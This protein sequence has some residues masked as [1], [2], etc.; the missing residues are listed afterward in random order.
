M[1]VM[2][3]KLSNSQCPE[4]P[5]KRILGEYVSGRLEEPQLGQCEA[6]LAHCDQCEETVRGMFGSDTAN[7]SF[8]GLAVEAL[9][10]EDASFS[11]D[12][13]LVD[14]LIR[15]LSGKTPD[16]DRDARALEN[17]AAEVTRLLPASESDGAVG[18]V[19]G[20]Q[21]I[22]LLGAGSTGI[23]YEATDQDLNRKVALKI[24]R[25]S[26]GDAA[27]DRFM[28]EAR[29]AAAIS[30]PNVITIYQVGV[31][32]P[33]A[34]IAME[35][36]EGQTLESRL[37]EVAFVPQDDIKKIGTQVAQGLAAAHRNG[38][39][40]RDIK[41]ANVWLKSENDQAVILDFGLARIADDD[42][43]MTATGMLAGT[44][45][46]M[47][48]EQ[49]RGLEL[50][51][52]SDL[53]SLGCLMYRASTGKLPF[54]TTGIL[55]TLQSIQHDDPRAPK[56]LNPHV[57]EDFSDLV[58]ALLEKQPVNRP[59]TADQLVEA[60]QS[61]RKQ[62]PF[63]VS[64]YGQRDFG[65]STR[66]ALPVTET[67]ARSKRFGG[68][69]WV[70]AALLLIGLGGLGWFFAP[71]IVRIATD[72]GEL[73]IDAKDEAVEVEVMNGGQRVRVIDTKTDQ[74]IEI[75]SGEYDLR[76]KDSTNGFRLSTNRVVLTRGDQEV[77]SIVRTADGDSANGSLGSEL[78]YAGKTFNEWMQ[79]VKT[80]RQ[81]KAKFGAL[82]AVAELAQGNDDLKKQVMDQ[83]KPLLRKYGSGAIGGDGPFTS[84]LGTK[85]GGLKNS[86]ANEELTHSFMEILRRFP[87]DDL[88]DF[89]IEEIK[90]GSA[91]SREFLTHVWTPGFMWDDPQG[92]LKQFRVIDE[93]AV[94]IATA[95]IKSAESC[96][97][98]SRQSLIESIRQ[99]ADVA[100][101]D[102][103]SGEDPLWLFNSSQPRKSAAKMSV[104]WKALLN[105][106]FESEQ[107]LKRAMVAV[108]MLRTFPDQSNL[109]VAFAKLLA[110][111]EVS[112][113][114]RN[115][116]L[117][118][119]EELLSEKIK[120][121]AGML[122][123]VGKQSGP[124]KD[125]MKTWIEKHI[126]RFQPNVDVRIAL[127]LSKLAD[128][129]QEL[130]S[131]LK[132]L[133]AKAEAD[134]GRPRF[135]VP[136]QLVKMNKQS[137]AH[138]R[139]AVDPDYEPPAEPKPREG[140]VF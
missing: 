25:P 102:W 24:L 136:D 35:L 140:G 124:T 67:A 125:R 82:A 61:E 49:T 45:N 103:D 97:E 48:P 17:R 14:Q 106:A 76:L 27:R 85:R 133:Q 120:P 13:P 77:V 33:L 36:T 113:Q 118:G 95:A 52:R 23:V 93:H 94:E 111:E 32:G 74:S 139:A 42:P 15:D 137:L 132:E 78:M 112:P 6:H 38:L 107:P 59:E 56:L 75:E 10:N 63:A 57:S 28:N 117:V 123:A 68:W 3:D 122:L 105:S 84:L 46:F 72:Q 43:Q 9:K 127:L 73:V 20:Y 92:Q 1:V 83:I 34:F 55:A 7:D 37:N 115:A 86:F 50:D 39:I 22:R 60:L 19:G 4:C 135:G 109:A 91:N 41:P 79:V 108:A 65:S 26:L 80:D 131:W 70:T 47:S 8:S 12:A 53:F 89:A 104:E 2:N 5:E 21:I 66:P 128:P 121:V 54:G 11:G 69:R 119:L 44:P 30:H 81:L 99:L 90:N 114:V 126:Y 31:E 96:D 100:V 58:M 101:V 98:R 40:H 62:W 29:A 134:P 130:L 116:G 88:M 64:M 129:P 110:D 87:A 16:S 138:A 18:Q 51:G 71:Q